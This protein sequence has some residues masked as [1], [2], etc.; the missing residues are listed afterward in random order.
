[1]VLVLKFAFNPAVLLPVGLLWALHRVLTG[2]PSSAWRC[3]PS[4]PPAFLAL[5]PPGALRPD[6]DLANSGWLVSTRPCWPFLPVLFLL[7]A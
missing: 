1:M 5:V 4:C 3:S 7:V 6:L 2:C